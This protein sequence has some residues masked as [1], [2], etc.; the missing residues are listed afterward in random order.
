VKDRPVNQPGEAGT[1]FD[2]NAYTAAGAQFSQTL[3]DATALL[4]EAR[5]LTE[6]ESVVRRVEE[7]VDAATRG[8]AD[9]KRETIDLIAWR[10]AQ[11]ITLTIVLLSLYTALI[12][13]LRRRG[14]I[15]DSR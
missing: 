1:P 7:V 4:H 15:A 13:W 10:A 5:D 9:Q 11:V 3:R 2:I 6:S 12:F 14:R 8:L